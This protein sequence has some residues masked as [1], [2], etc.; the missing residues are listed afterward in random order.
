[1]D[2]FFGT[3][4]RGAPLDEGGSLYRLEWDSK[5]IV[6]ET[7]IVPGAPS[8]DK[9]PNAELIL[10]LSTRQCGCCKDQDK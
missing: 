4:V 10:A 5:T 7:P 1:M 6:Q 3:I 9:D 2:V 8:V